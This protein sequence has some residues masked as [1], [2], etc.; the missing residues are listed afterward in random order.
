LGTLIVHDA[1]EPR[2]GADDVELLQKPE[3]SDVVFSVGLDAGY[4]DPA[5]GAGCVMFKRWVGA[6]DWAGPPVGCAYPF[7]WDTEPSKPMDVCDT[8]VEDSDRLMVVTEE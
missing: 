2:I 1:L 5:I 3:S 7:P 8:D 6:D 4:A